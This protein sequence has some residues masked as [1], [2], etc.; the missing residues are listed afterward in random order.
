TAP[1]APASANPAPV[2]SKVAAP[3]TAVS[4]PVAI[5]PTATKLADNPPIPD[6]DRD[7]W[8]MD[9]DDCEHHLVLTKDGTLS[10]EDEIDYR[11]VNIQSDIPLS[12]IEVQ[13]GSHGGE[14]VGDCDDDAEAPSGW[15]AT[16]RL[17]GVVVFTALSPG[18]VIERGQS[19]NGFKIRHHDGACCHEHH[20]YGPDT[21]AIH[22][23]DDDHEDC[24]C[25]VVSTTPVSWSGAKRMFK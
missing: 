16:I 7:N 20:G 21:R 8:D 13:G 25:A 3:T 5:R 23:D 4:A 9:S 12:R 22:D 19:M 24:T 1:V 17:D 11:V 14:H 10:S 2:V 6:N 15:N 18:D